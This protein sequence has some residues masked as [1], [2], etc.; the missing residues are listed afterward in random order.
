MHYRLAA[1]LTTLFLAVV[2]VS[3]CATRAP[4]PLE[5]SQNSPQDLA[6]VTVSPDEATFI[7]SQGV[8]NEALWGAFYSAEVIEKMD[9]VSAGDIKFALQNKFITLM[10]STQDWIKF[11]P[12][13][14]LATT[15]QSKKDR[16]S[17]AKLPSHTFDGSLV[18]QGKTLVLYLKS[19]EFH[20]GPLVVPRGTDKRDFG[21]VKIGVEA[22][23]VDTATQ[24][25]I[26]SQYREGVETIVNH[27]DLDLLDLLGYWD[28]AIEK[29][30][31]PLATSIN[32]DI[33]ESRRLQEQAVS[34]Q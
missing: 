33:S 27:R 21:W 7:N 22:Q 16:N 10:S 13:D 23:L 6:L 32:H 30:L 14:N 29:A 15:S 5:I 2:L 19:W 31:K 24:E 28:L 18:G 34:T 8:V 11:Q 25:L 12:I 4:F 20:A 3:S 9:G 1:K 17:N 26:W